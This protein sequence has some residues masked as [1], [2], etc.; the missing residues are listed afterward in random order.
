EHVLLALA[1]PLMERARVA[2]ARGELFR[3]TPITARAPD[4]AL[5]DGVIDLGF[6]E[7][8]ADGSRMVLVDYKTDAAIAD[9]SLYAQQLADYAS[10][11]AGALG[12]PVECILFRV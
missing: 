2:E 12:E 8:G 11:I 7:R 3:E 10:A 9:L 6:R 4:G 1:H 5:L